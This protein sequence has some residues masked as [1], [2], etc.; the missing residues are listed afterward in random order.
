MSLK[1][2]CKGQW[3]SILAALQVPKEFLQNKHGPCPF[4]GGTNRFR[5]DDK[6]FGRWICN[7]CGAGDGIEYVKR[8]FGVEFR[9]AATMIEKVVGTAKPVEVKQG[10]S[11][12]KVKQQMRDIWLASRP[13]AQV[14]P[15][16]AYW[17]NRVGQ[18]PDCPDL[19]GVE[20]LYCPGL[21]RE[22]AS[23]YCGMIAVMRDV[24]GD[25]VNLHRTWITWEGF[26]APVPDNKRVMPTDMKPGQ[27]VRLTPI[28]ETLGIAEGIE[29]A[30]AATILTGIPCWAATNAHLLEN[31]QPP[32]GVRRV[33]IF[34]DNDANYHGQ[35]ASYKLA[36]S[37]VKAKYEAEVRLPDVVGSDW[38]D[39]L[40]GLDKQ[41]A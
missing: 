38:N 26:K 37:L 5:F 34:G 33:V 3:P 39:V 16:S 29:N 9:E 28:A 22:E 13:V 11:P 40:V 20:R 14:D 15:V 35:T 4:C 7:Q 17:V 6:G 31:W 2:D 1:D 24:K 32:E 36:R 23:S 8:F 18:V 30:I 12:E 10:P 19:R 27:C 41:A 25:A 21:S